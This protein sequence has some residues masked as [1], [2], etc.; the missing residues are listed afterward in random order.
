MMMPTKP[1]QEIVDL[2]VEHIH[3]LGHKCTGLQGFLVFHALPEVIL[4]LVLEV[5][6]LTSALFLD[7]WFA[8]QCLRL[9]SLQ[10]L[11]LSGDYVLHKAQGEQKK[12]PSPR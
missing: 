10:T 8:V 7:V 9:A 6:Y 3:K 2:V 1:E 11:L 12:K 4:G 5:S